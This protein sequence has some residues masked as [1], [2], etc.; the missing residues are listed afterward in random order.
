[1]TLLENENNEEIGARARLD[2][3]FCARWKEGNQEWI[4]F[5]LHEA[6]APHP[7]ERSEWDGAIGEGKKFEKNALHL[8]KQ[9]RKY[10]A[11]VGRPI[12]VFGDSTALAG[13]IVDDGVLEELSDKSL[14]AKV[15]FEDD[16]KKFLP[17]LL[18]IGIRTLLEHG[19]VDEL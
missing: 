10:L 1:V 18:G 9:G 13:V 11:C 14:K 19:L 7:L 5:L 17:T 12:V 3:L 15:F 8:T 6:K 4:P 16:V 2:L